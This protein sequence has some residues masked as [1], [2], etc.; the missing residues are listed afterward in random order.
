MLPR[1]FPLSFPVKGCEKIAAS[2]L[3]V[4]RDAPQPLPQASSAG[5]PHHDES[6]WNI[7]VI[8]H[9]EEP[10]RRKAM[11]KSLH[12]CYA[13]FETRPRALLTMTEEPGTSR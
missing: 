11:K 2:R 12:H 9:P 4:V 5:A 7:T 3:R 10:A 13:W 8:R 1:G 6:I